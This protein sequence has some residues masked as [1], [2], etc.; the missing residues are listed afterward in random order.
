LAQAKKAQP[1]KV[2]TAK[3]SIDFVKKAV[4]SRAEAPAESASDNT[5]LQQQ[6]IEGAKMNYSKQFML[7]MLGGGDT[8]DLATEQL[9]DQFQVVYQGSLKEITNPGETIVLQEATPM[10]AAD[11]GWLKVYG[12]ADGSALVHKESDG[13]F[14][15]WESQHTQRPPGQ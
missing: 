1:T 4:A 15:P 14:E 6:T 9:H 3:A 11:G 13:N 8:N 10:R 7:A 2:D 12:F 5:V